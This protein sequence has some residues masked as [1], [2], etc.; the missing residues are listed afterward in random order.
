[1]AQDGRLQC[2]VGTGDVKSDDP[3]PREVWT[4]VALTYNKDKPIRCAI[5]G[6]P[7]GTPVSASISG[8]TT[9][10]AVQLG[11]CPPAVAQLVDVD[12]VRLIAA[13]RSD[14]EILEDALRPLNVGPPRGNL[15]HIDF[16][17]P[18]ASFTPVTGANPP[19]ACTT[20]GNE[21]CQADQSKAG[22]NAKLTDGQIVPGVEGMVFDT[23]VGRPQS[24]S[25]SPVPA[26]GQVLIP[27][28]N[29]LCLADAVTAELWI[30]TASTQMGEARLIGKWDGAALPGWRLQMTP[31]GRLRWEVVTQNT[32]S[33]GGP[34]SNTRSV[35]ITEEIVKD[36][37]WHHV[38]ATYDGQRLRVFRDGLPMH[39]WCGSGPREGTLPDE[40]DIENCLFPTQIENCPPIETKLAPDVRPL[41]N[42]ARLRIGDTVC[43]Q[44]TIDNAQPILVANDDENNQLDGWIDEIRVSNY[45][46]REFEVA[47]SSR[48]A[49]AFTQTLGRETILR[50]RFIWLNGKLVGEESNDVPHDLAQQPA[51][52]LRASDLEGR[53][54]SGLKHVL[55]QRSADDYFLGRATPDSLGRNGLLEYP[56][57]EV[58]ASQSD[59]DGTFKSLKGYGPGIGDSTTQQPDNCDPS[60]TLIGWRQSQ[61]YI[62]NATSTVTGRLANLEY[63]N[64]VKSAWTYDDGPVRTAAASQPSGAFGPDSLKTS[65]VKSSSGTTLSDRI[66]DWDVVGNLKHV[67]DNSGGNYDAVYTYDDL[68]R[69]KSATL[70]LS[71]QPTSL[72]LFYD[73][74]ALGNLTLIDGKDPQRNLRQNEG[75]RQNYGRTASCQTAGPHALTERTVLTGTPAAEKTDPL[76]YDAAGRL[77]KATDTLRNSINT[78]RYYA[79]SK[80]STITDRNGESR[81]LYDGNGN[82]VSKSEQGWG[83]Q[84]ILG[85]SYREMAISP[86]S[87]SFEAMYP[88]ALKTL[89]DGS[90]HEPMRTRR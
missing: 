31:A 42:G 25:A 79:R 85:P 49:S 65:T 83:N 7:Q 11:Q 12:Q 40:P 82:R 24:L 86:P 77:V 23:V 13:A 66:Y 26:T 69:V 89:C 55:G 47:A 44:G 34:T 9:L 14:A 10:S 28:L 54:V 62:C 75:A 50:N 15:V 72:D 8:S 35:F 19:G 22:N 46:K 43:I 87:Q 78:Y 6:V 37:T 20:A 30:K 80:V 56:H 16:G 90:C 88:W 74:D 61:A 64:G 71:Q 51:R 48:L 32:P 76:C 45:A 39:R 81:Y 29:T 4:H 59:L 60:S 70:T 21:L 53:L 38:A 58:V 67:S 41:P 1:M 52:E 63:G 73:Y 3:L 68:R 33:S 5:N 36:G 18:M 27:H 57:G 2:K 17:H 84:I